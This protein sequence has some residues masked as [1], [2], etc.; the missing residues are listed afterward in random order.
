MLS[1]HREENPHVSQNGKQLRCYLTNVL[2]PYQLTMEQIARLYA[3]QAH[4]EATV[5]L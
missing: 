2:D 3:Q 5:K 1:L 4:L